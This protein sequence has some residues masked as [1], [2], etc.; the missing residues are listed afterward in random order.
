MR[1]LLPGRR[2]TLLSL[3]LLLALPS[4]SAANIAPAVRD[5]N[6]IPSAPTFA[7]KLRR[8]FF[9]PDSFPAANWSPSAINIYK[10]DVAKVLDTM[11]LVLNSE[12]GD[13][14]FS[15]PV[16]GRVTSGFGPRRMWSFHYHFGTDVK[17]AVGDTVVAAMDGVIRVV[18]YDSGYG[19]FIV[20]AHENGLETLYGHLHSTLVQSGQEVKSGD[21]I[22]LGGNTGRST[23]AH[24]HF[25]FR[26]MGA[27]FD[28][29]RLLGFEDGEVL[30]DEFDL[31]PSW[32]KYL[33]DMRAAKYH[34]V[35]RGDNLGR[36]AR[37]YG[38]T[39]QRVAKING[40]RT[41][42]LLRVGRRIRVL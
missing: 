42:T 20:I 19:N 14:K 22:A 12:N 35:R 7:L 15:F 32:F 18:R 33:T 27:Q 25:E 28:A 30:A 3:A 5:S 10:T 23:G 37:R 21:A 31:D 4:L 29:G 24:L 34:Y 9:I 40:M 38:T 36:I 6:D 2:S 13:K 16:R 41:N 17:L 26:F 8:E 11:H 39:V 1:P